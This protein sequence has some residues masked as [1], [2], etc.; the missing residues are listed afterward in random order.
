M[1]TGIVCACVYDISMSTSVVVYSHAV[2]MRVYI[3]ACICVIMTGCV[4]SELLRLW[5]MRITFYVHAFTLSIL[6]VCVCVCVNMTV[7]VYGIII[8]TTVCVHGIIM[9][10]FVY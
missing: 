8:T 1:Q 4:H 7:C 5:T 3:C 9:C 10:V 2:C 6:R